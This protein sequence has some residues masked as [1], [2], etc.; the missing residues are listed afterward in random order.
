MANMSKVSLQYQIPR[1]GEQ[2][3][4]VSIPYPTPGPDE[5]CIRTRAVGLNPVDWKNRAFGVTVKTWPAV[6]G[7]DAAGIIDSVGESTED[8]KPGD[9]VFGLCGTDNRGGA[10]QEIVTIPSQLIAKKPPSLSFEEAASLP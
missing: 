4:K 7:I 8:F 5:V 2:F 1:Q 6:L 9:E 10:F 3:A